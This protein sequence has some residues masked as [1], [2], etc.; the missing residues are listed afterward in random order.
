MIAPYKTRRPHASNTGDGVLHEPQNPIHMIRQLDQ[1]L[2]GW[3]TARG[4]VALLDSIE[5]LADDHAGR[6]AHDT[7]D[8]C[9]LLGT[10]AA[11]LG[12]CWTASG[13]KAVS[14]GR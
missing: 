6:D 7:V 13:W 12:Y 2:P 14:H 10:T 3:E 5:A 9:A 8:M 11:Y 1:C 4:P